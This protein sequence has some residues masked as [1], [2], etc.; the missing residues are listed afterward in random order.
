MGG[1]GGVRDPTA[2]SKSVEEDVSE[3]DEDGDGDEDGDEDEAFEVEEIVAERMVERRRKGGNRQEVLFLVHWKGYADDN[4]DRSSWEPLAGVA[5]TEALEL[6]RA[7]QAASI[8]APTQRAVAT[9]APRFPGRGKAEDGTPGRHCA[10]DEVADA[11]A[12]NGTKGD[13]TDTGDAATTDI[14]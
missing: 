4:P 13:P 1:E 11:A 3:M 7:K 9:L 6:F 10:A 2:D 14:R 12:P 8:L 5:H